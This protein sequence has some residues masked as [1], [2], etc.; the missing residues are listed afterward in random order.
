[1]G[2]GER[3]GRPTRGRPL[4][5]RCHEWNIRVENPEETLPRLAERCHQIPGM[6]LPVLNKA[7][8]RRSQLLTRAMVEKHTFDLDELSMRLNAL[9]S[10]VRCLEKLRRIVISAARARSGSRRT[11]LP[12]KDGTSKLEPAC[13]GRTS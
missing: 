5:K 2:T 11:V 4:A 1:M 12:A 9:A 6:A 3:F 7:H 13:R 8:K 10:L